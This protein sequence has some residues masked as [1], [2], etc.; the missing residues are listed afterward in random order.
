M[1]IHGV[2]VG[3]KHLTAAPCSSGSSVGG[4][5]GGMPLAVAASAASHC[6]EG[7][8]ASPACWDPS[9]CW[10]WRVAMWPLRR[11]SAL[12]LSGCVSDVSAGLASAAPAASAACCTSVAAAG[13][14]QSSVLQQVVSH[15]A[16]DTGVCR[17]APADESTAGCHKTGSPS[18]AST[19]GADREQH[20]SVAAPAASCGR[21]IPTAGTVEACCRD[22]CGG[23]GAAAGCCMLPGAPCRVA[24]T[25]ELALPTSPDISAE[26]PPETSACCRRCQNSWASGRTY[27][28]PSRIMFSLEQR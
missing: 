28:Q 12:G 8:A 2:R 6:S 7:P 13:A 5:S 21:A 9:E 1:R 27:Q 19:P 11:R 16:S 10:P 23:Q 26:C 17:D 15:G 14:L 18:T 20:A 22:A 3:D 25:S 4:R 24:C